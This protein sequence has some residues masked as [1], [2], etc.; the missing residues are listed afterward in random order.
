MGGSEHV[1]SAQYGLLTD[2]HSEIRAETMVIQV[3]LWSADAFKE[4]NMVKSTSASP[5]IS[6]TTQCSYAQLEQSTPA[7]ASILPSNRG[8]PAYT[9]QVGYGLPAVNPYAMSTHGQYPGKL[10][11]L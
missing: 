8:E 1:L 10:Q 11:T 4:V 7:F 6:S 9:A 5:S 2:Y 3:D